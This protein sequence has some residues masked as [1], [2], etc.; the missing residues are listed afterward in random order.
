MPETPS[1]LEITWP[2][3]GRYTN[4]TR[5]VSFLFVFRATGVAEKAQ[6]QNAQARVFAI[7]N[8]QVFCP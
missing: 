7:I 6:L 3:I 8:L 2:F 4:L 5:G 1:R